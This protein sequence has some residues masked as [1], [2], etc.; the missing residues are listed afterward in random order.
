MRAPMTD[1]IIID[2][3]NG[4]FGAYVAQPNTVP[5]PANQPSPALV[6]RATFPSYHLP[7]MRAIGSSIN[8]AQNPK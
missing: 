1:R 7:R 8:V 4:A 6:F 5:V 3:R 2:G